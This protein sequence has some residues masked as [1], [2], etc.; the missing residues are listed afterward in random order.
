MDHRQWTD[1]PPEQS[2]K[3]EVSTLGAPCTIDYRPWTDN[4]LP[5][6]RKSESQHLGR[7]MDYRP[8]TMDHVPTRL[9]YPYAF[10]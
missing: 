4:S 8:S 7:T 9:L 6:S 3:S 5:P 2:Q 1:N 10:A